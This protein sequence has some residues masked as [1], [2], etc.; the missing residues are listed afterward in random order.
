MFSTKSSFVLIV[1]MGLAVSACNTNRGAL[2]PEEKARLE[3]Q[4]VLPT[5]VS[6]P[7]GTYTVTATCADS[8]KTEKLKDL[9]WTVKI[10]DGGNYLESQQN[11]D[12]RCEDAC[13]SAE[14]GSVNVNELQA[15]FTAKKKLNL[16]ENIFEDITTPIKKIY[17]ISNYDPSAGLLELI[18]NTTLNVCQGKMI[19][20]L[21]K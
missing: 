7:K 3:E 10:K 11:F 14:V 8:T 17:F 2:T 15:T 5:Y 6:L 21:R 9:H 4:K 13:S 18:D 20:K 16:E 19:L 1:V 12:A